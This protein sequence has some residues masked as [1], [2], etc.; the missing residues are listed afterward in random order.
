MEFSDRVNSMHS[1][2]ALIFFLT[3]FTHFYN[4]HY[5]MISADMMSFL[6]LHISAFVQYEN[7]DFMI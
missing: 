5:N 7:V 3:L 2:T 1:C 6:T 4:T